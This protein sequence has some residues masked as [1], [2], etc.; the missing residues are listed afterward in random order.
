MTIDHVEKI[1]FKDLKEPWVKF[2]CYLKART[3]ELKVSDRNPLPNLLSAPSRPV[4]RILK[5]GCTP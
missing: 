3:K 2:C 4:D 5:R 1:G